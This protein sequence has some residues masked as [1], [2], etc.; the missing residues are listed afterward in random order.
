MIRTHFVVL[1]A[2]QISIDVDSGIFDFDWNWITTD[3]DDYD[4]VALLTT[5][6]TFVLSSYWDDLFGFPCWRR[7]SEREDK[8]IHCLTMSNEL[9]RTFQTNS[10]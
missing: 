7:V 6:T 5:T 2:S 8:S 1:S 10:N 4:D 3:D 9:E